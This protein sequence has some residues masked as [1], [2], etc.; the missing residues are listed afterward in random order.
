MVS[1]F[2]K[3]CSEI[4]VATR[5]NAVRNNS[6]QMRFDPRYRNNRS[7]KLTKIIKESFFYSNSSSSTLVDLIF[8]ETNFCEIYS[9]WNKI[10]NEIITSKD[11]IKFHDHPLNFRDF[12]RLISATPW[13]LPPCSKS[14]KLPIPTPLIPKAKIPRYHVPD[15][16]RSASYQ[17]ESNS[18]HRLPGS[19][20][21]GVEDER[22]SID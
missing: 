18:R 13:T 9:N 14:Y 6:V 11:I 1:Q 19:P 22:I 12:V 4:R 20:R 7:G 21:T 10:L 3:V 17:S 5:A 15:P 8:Y 2:L 16:I